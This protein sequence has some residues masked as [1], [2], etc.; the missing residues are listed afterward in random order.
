[1]S[2]ARAI[3]ILMYHSVSEGP[4]PIS[5]A[6]ADFRM[7]MALLGECGY[8]AVG[9]DDVA[10]WQR[11]ERE[12][13][14][15]TVVL[16]FDD[17]FD[18]FADVAFPE[19]QSRGWTATLFLPAGKIGGTADWER[20]AGGP[21][22]RRLISWQTAG[23]LAQRGIELGAHGF[24][25]TDLT[26]LSPE[27]ARQEIAGSKS[28][29]EDRA[30]C[31]VTSFAAPYGRTNAALRKEIGRHVPLA[32]GTRLGAARRGS[33]PY[34]LPRIEMWYFRNPRRWRA[35]LLGRANGYFA[36]RRAL[37]TV[38]ALVAGG[39]G[40]GSQPRGTPEGTAV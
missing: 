30:G 39:P 36:L 25:H 5:I 32:V 15:R 13:P 23:E 21:S 37:R 1:M 9:L 20:R 3:S 27:A 4:G 34:D 22:A 6:P 7:Q 24:S 8:N 16:T 35:Y 28:M 19:L 18:D 10:A 33:D 12:L 11:G 40:A 14:C 29:I 31:R 38:R 2:D 17:G 26:T